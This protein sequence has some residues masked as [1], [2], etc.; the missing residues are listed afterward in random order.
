M[1]K[2]EHSLFCDY[3]V[4]YQHFLKLGVNQIICHLILVYNHRSNKTELFLKLT[5]MMKQLFELGSEKIRVGQEVIVTI[6][7]DGEFSG[8][9]SLINAKR[10]RLHVR[11]KS[12]LLHCIY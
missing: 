11:I 7:N 1:P 4:I 3:S 8:K 5:P 9:I 6:V 2:F 10:D 12:F